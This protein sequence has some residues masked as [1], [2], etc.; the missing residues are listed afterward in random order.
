MYLN[1]EQ[2][3][4]LQKLSNINISESEQQSFLQK[5]EPVISKLNE[6]ANVDVSDL[7][8]TS[9]NENTL[10]SLGWPKEFWNKKK[11]IDNVNHEILNNSIVIKSVLS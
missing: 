6:L 3:N 4:H 1:Q 7:K 9:Q 10:R 11:I 2:L 8:D 5:L